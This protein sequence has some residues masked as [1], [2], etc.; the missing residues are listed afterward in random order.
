MLTFI[1]KSFLGHSTSKNHHNFSP[2]AGMAHKTTSSALKWSNPCFKVP[3]Q[4]ASD[5]NLYYQIVS[6]PFYKQKSSKFFACGGH[7]LAHITTSFEVP[8]K[9]ASNVRPHYQ[10][11][12]RP[13]YEKKSSKIFACGGYLL[14]HRKFYPGMKKSKLK[15]ISR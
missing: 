12:S 10:I 2:A 11:V 6:R 5:V 3:W 15:K 7:I 13:F 4:S 9:S 14:A 1:T 8:W